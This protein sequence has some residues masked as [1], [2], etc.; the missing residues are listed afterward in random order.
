[1]SM[2]DKVAR[3]EAEHAATQLVKDCGYSSLPVCPFEIAKKHD[4]HVEAKPSSKPGVSGFLMRVGNAFGIR[5]AQHIQ[6]EG[7]IRFTVAHELGHY[8]L[9]GHAETLFPNGDGIHASKSGFISGNPLE[10]QADCFASALLMP[11]HLFQ[12]AVDNAGTG[13]PAIEKLAKLCKTSIT[14][15]AIRFTQF[16]EEAVAVIVS[17][18]QQIDYCFMSERIRDLRGI[19]WIRKGDTLPVGITRTFNADATNITEARQEEGSC[20]L[21]DWFDG[22]P[23]VEVNED[24][25]GLGSYGKTLTVLF[26]SE[27]LE[28]D[29]D[30]EDD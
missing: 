9:P 2:S 17:N 6:N 16:A 18:G 19:T 21:D 29:E 3:A 27:A 5:Y 24:V 20:F 15:T 14:S 22:A 11:D 1:M 13:F 30:D 10:R 4:I 25:V 28:D 23:Q 7:F 12:K 26:T 8:F